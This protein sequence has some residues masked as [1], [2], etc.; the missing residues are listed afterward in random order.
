M[1]ER[2]SNNEILQFL[3]RIKL[4]SEVPKLKKSLYNKENID[5]TEAH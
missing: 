3:L 2:E 4:G 1:S 5:V